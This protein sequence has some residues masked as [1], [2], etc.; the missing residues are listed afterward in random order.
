MELL[1]ESRTN[2]SVFSGTLH[3]VQ[4]KPE[5]HLEPVVLPDTFV[6]AHGVSAYGTVLNDGGRLRMWYQA[7][8]KD[9]EFGLDVSLVAHAESADGIHW[10]KTPLDI[11]EHGGEPNHLC[12]LG[13]HSPAIFVDPEAPPER[14]YR[15]TGCG[16]PSMGTR[17][18]R[19]GYY[20]AYSADGLRWHFDSSEPQWEGGDVITSI[21][22]PGRDGGVVALKNEIWCNRLFRRA[23]RTAKYRRGAFTDSVSALIPDEYDDVAA[24]QRGYFSTDYYGMGLLAAGRG[25][26]GF[27]WNFR[28]DLP[29][30]RSTAGNRGNSDITLVYQEEEGGRWQHLP[31]RPDF[32]SHLDLPWTEQGWI[33]SSSQ[34]VEV[35]DE[36]RLYFSGCNFDHGLYIKE[37]KTVPRWLDWMKRS[38]F[39][40]IT[41]AR[42]PKF[43]LF[44]F[45]S[46]EA[47][48]FQVRIDD[49]NEDGEL[50]LNYRARKGG[51]V[52]VSIEGRP[53]YSWDD[54]FPLDGDAVSAPV[55]WKGGTHVEA[56]NEGPLTVTVHLEMAAVF[57]YQFVTKN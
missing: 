16:K 4:W 43:R 26:A 53:G 19:Y 32:I 3:F 20:A 13:L 25:V 5:I 37:G 18:G 42:W 22:H 14:R 47:A 30:S 51:A 48:S 52:R 28:H 54:C 8:P 12:D 33:H 44:G 7:W 29:F 49:A 45:E 31:G 21:Y 1:F 17:T 27:V 38:S 41:F 39:S 57:A 24:A 34:P 2:L 10:K 23:I 50:R 15:A 11:V 55:R 6:D 35:G 9:W 56:G 46:T 40:G 36:H